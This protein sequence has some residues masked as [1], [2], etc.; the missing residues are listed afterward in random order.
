MTRS[1]LLTSVALSVIVVGA[2]GGGT[3]TP[4][5][6]PLTGEEASRMAAVQYDNLRVG[7]AD[8][9]VAAAIAA[10][11]E[12]ISLSGTVDWKGHMG[13]ARVSARGREA[14]LTEIAWVG[15]NIL[16]RRSDVA[17]LLSGLG[18][19]AESWI[20][21]PSDPTSRSID[22]IV[23]LLARLSSSE[24]DNALIIQQKE[25]SAWMRTDTLRGT[26]VE[27]LRYGTQT[28]YWL[29]AGTGELLRFEGN[30]SALNAPVIADFTSR[31]PRTIAL[32]APTE[33]VQVDQIMDLYGAITNP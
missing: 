28:I 33:A 27:V 5:E 30:S 14:P 9:T 21:R 25:G 12:E 8:F 16:E 13:R 24:P 11:G 2:C 23:A 6:R 20:L 1:R 17:P 22:R 19:S 32:P 31:G 7:G 29:D 10:T 26:P 3:S 15:G 4:S 18:Y